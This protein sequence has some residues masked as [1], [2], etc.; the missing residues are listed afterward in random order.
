[1]SRQDSQTQ[2]QPTPDAEEDAR[3]TEQDGIL[4]LTID[5]QRKRNAISTQVTE[6]LWQAG[7]MLA[8][9]DDLRCL[10]ITGV[11][12][13]FTAG[14]DLSQPVGNRPGNPETQHLHPGWNLRRDY[15]SHHLLYDEF[16]AIEK[17]II[18]AAN[19]I[20][21]GAG[22]EMAVSC[23]FRFCTPQAEF[24]V[25]E[26]HIGT[27]A[28]SGGTSR[29]TRL[30]GPGWGK[31]MAMAGKRVGAEQAK[32]IGLVHDVF[33]AETFMEDVYAF[34]RE[35]TTIPAEVLGVAKLVVDMYADVH[36]RTVQRHIDRLAVTS[37]SYSPDFLNRAAKFGFKPRYAVPSW[38]R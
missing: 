9:R 30:V 4:T 16:E 25:P 8:D 23:D 7:D 19:G 22:V 3:L 28:G 18:I 37:L 17:P 38:E 29:L 1:M 35:L 14:M 13:Y 31:W 21:L 5:R 15:R 6:L 26:V 10:V 27:I 36:D 12:P 32:Q 20:C 2:D 33:P 34:C 24:G 11:G